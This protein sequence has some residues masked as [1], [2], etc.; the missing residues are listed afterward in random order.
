MTESTDNSTPPPSE[1]FV[2][3]F[4]RH[5]RRL[6]LFILSQWPNP[7]EAEEI[8]QEANVIIWT[9]YSQFMP[10][11]NFFAWTCQIA[12]YEFLKHR[13]RRIKDR[14]QFSDEFVSMV[15]DEVE[16]RSDALDYRREALISCLR[17]LN[18][19]DR[20]LIQKRYSPGQSGKTVAE[21]LNRPANAVYQSLSRIRRTLHVCINRQLT[22]IGME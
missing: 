14:L 8:L 12:R 10:G 18:P 6:Y 5:Q 7:I 19:K 9:K 20:E 17:K 16:Q 15:A 22:S 2:Q 1:E 21:F 4:T 3:L 11:T 13:E